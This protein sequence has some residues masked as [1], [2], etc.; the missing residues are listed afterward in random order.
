MDPECTNSEIEARKFTIQPHFRSHFG[1]QVIL[2]RDEELPVRTVVSRFSVLSHSHPKC[3][4]QTPSKI[5]EPECSWHLF[6]MCF[7]SVS[8]YPLS[9]FVVCSF[10]F[11]HHAIAAGEF[12]NDFNASYTTQ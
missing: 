11:L 4:S 7:A 6:R 10:N 12:C 8:I 5:D 1:E 9:I 3:S 2:L